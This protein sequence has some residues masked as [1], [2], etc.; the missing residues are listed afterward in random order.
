MGR[1]EA[2]PALCW[3][4]KNVP[5][6]WKEGLGCIHLCVKFSIQNVV[7]RVSSRK[8]FQNFSLR[9][10]LFLCFWRNLC[11]NAQIPRYIPCP[12]KFQVAR[13]W[14]RYVSQLQASN[15]IVSFEKEACSEDLIIFDSYSSPTQTIEAYLRPLLSFSSNFF[16][17]WNISLTKI[18]CGE[19]VYTNFGV[20]TTILNTV[21]VFCR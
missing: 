15:S 5:W 18:W 8:N 14:S 16:Y 17:I 4:S 9:S 13:L 11:R 10:V 2:S 3:K 6:Y 20:S 7:L 1:G 19:Y 21:E 12:E